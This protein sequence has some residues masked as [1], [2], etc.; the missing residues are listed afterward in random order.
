VPRKPNP[1]RSE[2]ITVYLTPGMKRYLQDLLDTH[3]SGKTESAAAERLIE[4]GIKAEIQDG[5]IKRRSF[6]KAGKSK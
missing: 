4:R 5:T 1:I 6:P 2:E 3:L